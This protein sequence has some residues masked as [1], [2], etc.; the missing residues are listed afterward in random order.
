MLGTA[1][2]QLQF[3]PTYPS[4]LC[5]PNMGDRGHYSSRRLPRF[6]VHSKIRIDSEP[7]A[8]FVELSLVQIVAAYPCHAAALSFSRSANQFINDCIAHH[9]QQHPQ[10]YTWWYSMQYDADTRE[11]HS[12]K[13]SHVQ[14]LA[15]AFE[16]GLPWI[17]Y[18][19]RR[20]LYNGQANQDLLE[21]AISRL[22]DDAFVTRDANG[23]RAPLI[24]PP[25]TPSCCS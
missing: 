14:T 16:C 15:C 22:F 18:V 23:V 1:G 8:A 12:M 11:F 24:R 20:Y 13:D 5:R 7:S 19:A 25:Q 21:E 2:P 4:W 10:W 17:I 9:S 3:H 6:P